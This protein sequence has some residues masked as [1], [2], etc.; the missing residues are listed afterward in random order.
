MK[1]VRPKKIPTVTVPPAVSVPSETVSTAGLSKSDPEYFKK[2][3]QISAKKR[4]MSS[5]DFAAMAKLS[6]PRP[7]GSYKG[8]RKKKAT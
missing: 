1:T 4:K 6:H 5:E 2:I 8:G 3:G 7:K